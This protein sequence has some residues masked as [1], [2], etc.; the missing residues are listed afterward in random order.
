MTTIG[1]EPAFLS[2]AEFVKFWDEDARRSDDAVR[3]IGKVAG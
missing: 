2:A 1:L 3:Q